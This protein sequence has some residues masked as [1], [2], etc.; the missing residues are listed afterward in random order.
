MQVPRLPSADD[1][2]SAH[3]RWEQLRLVGADPFIYAGPGIIVD[4]IDS[5]YRIRT[6]NT[7]DPQ[8][9]TALAVAKITDIADLADDYLTVR[10]LDTS[11]TETGAPYLVALPEH[12]RAGYAPTTPGGW[13]HA[14]PAVRPAYAVGQ[15]IL[16]AQVTYTG[17]VDGSANPILWL[18]LNLDARQWSVTVQY[19]YDSTLYNLPVLIGDNITLV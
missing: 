17:V 15:Q 8:T 3:H 12:L 1:R 2:H 6:R 11:G 9:A 13:P 18:D 7:Q 10:A 4:V 14:A 16:T 5:R 19:C